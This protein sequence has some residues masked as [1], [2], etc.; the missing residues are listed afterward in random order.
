M[1]INLYE[2]YHN[3]DVKLPII[4]GLTDIDV[5]P[6][7]DIQHLASE[8]GLDEDIMKCVPFIETQVP[9]SIHLLLIRSYKISGYHS[10][11]G[12]FFFHFQ[13]PSLVN[14]VREALTKGNWIVLQNCHLL[15]TFSS[16]LEFLNNYVFNSKSINPQFRLWIVTF[17]FNE[18][19]SD[20][21]SKGNTISHL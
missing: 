21:S 3:T 6:L 10:S 15:K 20:V 13:I 19:P 14:S 5:D 18:F 11:K 9:T 12:E 2:I 16:Y 7:M 17:P 8:M 1:Q 4:C